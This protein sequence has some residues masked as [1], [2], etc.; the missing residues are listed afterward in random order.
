MTWGELKAYCEKMNVP[1]N[2][3]VMVLNEHRNDCGFGAEGYDYVWGPFYCRE[4]RS[5]NIE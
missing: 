5:L 2:A 1:D 3:E 4:D